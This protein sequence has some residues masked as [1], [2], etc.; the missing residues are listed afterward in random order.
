MNLKVLLPFQIFVEKDDVSRI[1]AETRAGS[2]G[3]LPHRRD[4]VAEIVPGILI[5]ES[6]SEGEICLAVDE[7]ILVKTGLNV[8]V[9]VRNAIGGTDLEQ[10]REEVEREFVN[11]NEREQHIRTVMDKMERGLITRMARLHRD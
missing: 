2:F 10:L 4:C 8:T 5:Y 9:S 3:L 6:E 7:G 1:V 11:L